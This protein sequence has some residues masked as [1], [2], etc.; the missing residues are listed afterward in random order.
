MSRAAKTMRVDK[1]VVEPAWCF[2]PEIRSLQVM[3]PIV[4]GSVECRFA[5]AGPL[6]RPFDPVGADDR[7]G[8]RR[9]R[10]PVEMRLQQWPHQLPPLL[11]QQGFEIAVGRITQSSEAT[12]NTGLTRI[13][14]IMVHSGVK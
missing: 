7:L 8:G 3:A 14:C 11:L 6:V 4:E 2:H 10:P 5:R 12:R 9:L 13:W 1:P